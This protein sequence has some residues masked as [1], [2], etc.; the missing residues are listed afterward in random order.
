MDVFDECVLGIFREFPILIAQYKTYTDGPYNPDTGS[1]SQTV[2]STD[3]EAI[4]MDLTLQSNGLSTKF[5][6]LVIAGD[7]ELFVRPRHKTNP[8]KPIMAINPATDRV[9]VNGI[10]YKIVTFKEI[11]PTGADPILYDLYLRR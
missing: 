2:T 5:G 11:N 3:V 10:T 9:V 1:V 8:T 6:T 4:M 7:K